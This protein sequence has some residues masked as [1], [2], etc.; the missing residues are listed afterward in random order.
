[1]LL[2]RLVMLSIVLVSYQRTPLNIIKNKQVNK[3]SREVICGP[4]FEVIN[5]LLSLRNLKSNLVLIITWEMR[6]S[7]VHVNH[8]S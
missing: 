7:V 2:S 8:D 1:M 6:S 3:C 5:A 4:Y